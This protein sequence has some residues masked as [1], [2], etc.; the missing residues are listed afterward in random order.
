MSN[1]SSP[2]SIKGDLIRIS[3]VRRFVIDLLHFAKKVPLLPMQRTM[4]L[5]RVIEARNTVDPHVSWVA[6]FIKA[7]G[8]LAS[9][10]P[11]LRRA[12]IP[13]PWPY[14]YQH[15]TSVASF[16]LERKV[17]EEYGI[18]FGKITG[19]ESRSLEAIDSYVRLLRTADID[20]VPS[21]VVA[22]RISRVPNPLRRWIWWLGLS[23]DGGTRAHHFGTFG[24]SVVA[25]F[26]AASL[27]LLSPLTTTINYGVLQSDGHLDVRLMYDHRVMDG[28]FVARRMIDFEDIL[29]TQI[30]EELQDIAARREFNRQAEAA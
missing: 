2:V 20:S 4:D 24:I 1:L 5:T 10:F 21:F 25:S 26:G 7:Y 30:V 8:I 16:S 13:F 28:A 9:Q 17:G 27:T 15:P 14:F 22:S 19:P 11:E 29:Q 23:T 12:Y 18:F 6:I 3:P